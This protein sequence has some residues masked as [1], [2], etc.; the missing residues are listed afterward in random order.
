MSLTLGDNFSYQASKPLDARLKYDTVANMK[1]VADATMYDGCLAYCSA[2]D[3]TYQWKSTNSVDTTTGR[4]REFSSGGGGGASS[5]SDLTDTNISNPT[6]N[7]VL[8]YNDS[9]NKWD[10]MNIQDQTTDCFKASSSAVS[11]LDDADSLPVRQDRGGSTY[12]N[13]IAWSNI[14]SI[15]K[16]Y[17]DT[18]Y[19][20]VTAGTGLSLANNEMS[21]KEFASGDMEEIMTPLPSSASKYMNYS[22]EEQVV[23]QWVDGKTVYQKTFTGTWSSATTGIEDKTMGTIPTGAT[24]VKLYGNTATSFGS[25]PMPLL[26]WNTTYSRIDY[27][28]TLYEENKTIKAYRY[29]YSIATMASNSLSVTVQYTKS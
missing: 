4:W 14:K 28:T 6:H 9:T 21:I 13:I 17:F 22:T 26:N 5:L 10:N 2:T 29:G 16:T 25:V 3:K 11:A 7:Q 20:T 8:G 19:S 1:A 18:I 27:G 24:V 23:G 12:K 15:L